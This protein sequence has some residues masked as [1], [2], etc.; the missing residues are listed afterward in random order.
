[1]HPTMRIGGAEQLV[2]NLALALIREGHQ[3]TIYT[4]EH[5]KDSFPE[6]LDG[7]IPVTQCGTFFGIV[8]KSI[9]NRFQA[10]LAM[11]RMFLCTMWMLCYGPSYDIVVCDIV[12]LPLPLLKMFG[13]KTVYY[14]H[15]P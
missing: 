3:A 15:F 14:C 2:V 4:P 9:F 7:T 1:M 10:A 8:P 12:T 6:T 5:L 11:I 13:S